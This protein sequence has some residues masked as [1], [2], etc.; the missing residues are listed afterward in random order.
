MRFSLLKVIPILVGVLCLLPG[1]VSA[2]CL[3][4]PTSA[5]QAELVWA[6][7]A[8]ITAQSSS[9]PDLVKLKTYPGPP[10]PATGSYSGYANSWCFNL[11][12]ENN[13]IA[14]QVQ[15]GPGQIGFWDEAGISLGSYT[16]EQADFPAW[17][18]QGNFTSGTIAGSE[19]L[20]PQEYCHGCVQAHLGGRAQGTLSF[21]FQYNLIAQVADLVD[22]QPLPVSLVA[23]ETAY[24]KFPV[25]TSAMVEQ[26]SSSGGTLYLQVIDMLGDIDAALRF[27]QAPTDSN[28]GWTDQQG[29]G[30]DETITV[31]EAEIGNWYARLIGVTDGGNGISGQV[32]FFMDYGTGDEPEITSGTPVPVSLAGGQTATY[33]FQVGVGASVINVTLTGQDGNLDLGLERSRPKSVAQATWSSCN[34]GGADE[35]ILLTST[36][37]KPGVWFVMVE[38]PES[39]PAS[40]TLSLTTDVPGSF[41]LPVPIGPDS[42]K[43]VDRLGLTWEVVES[44]VLEGSVQVV[45]AVSSP[46]L[47]PGDSH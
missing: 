9:H 26:Y 34:P 12:F 13:T 31:S 46:L 42:A 45:P 41:S 36:E 14:R 38:N 16:L 19:V 10:I 27:G 29:A 15:W 32:L 17:F 39:S 8:D 35:Q 28:P 4:E 6:M 22:G 20:E 1:G 33:K 21:S 11:G 7:F 23:G 30:V 43:P 37:I 3:D 5:D 2:Q 24:F 25:T 18:N 47:P 44:G 40:G